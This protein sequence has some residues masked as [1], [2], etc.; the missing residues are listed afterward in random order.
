METI[1]QKQAEL[2]VLYNGLEDPLMQY[3]FLLQLAGETPAPEKREETARIR[4]CQTDS[5]FQMKEKDGYF[6][7][8]VD[9][10][11]LLIRGVLS[12]YVYLLDG[13]K[14][15]EVVSTPLDFMEK[16]TISGQL[17]RS[18]FRVL[19]ALPEQIRQFCREHIR[20]E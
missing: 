19:A 5:W 10:E 3:E 18:R 7:L 20:E 14:L 11:S 1:A 4:N 8:R 2:I 9:S 6:F 15:R 17:T 13:R 12:I 16:T